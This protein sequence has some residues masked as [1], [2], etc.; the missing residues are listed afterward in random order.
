MQWLHVMTACATFSLFFMFVYCTQLTLTPSGGR[1]QRAYYRALYA[2]QISA[3]LG[4]A[5]AKNMPQMRNLAME[6]R[7]VCCHP[8]RL[9]R[10]HRRNQLGAV[11]SVY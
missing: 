3:L 8:V 5:T 11:G 9:M 6:L 2:N 7:K 10:S 4:G 1:P